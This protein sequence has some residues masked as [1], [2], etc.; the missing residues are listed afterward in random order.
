MRVR[1]LWRRA[2]EERASP[3]EIGWAIALGVFCGCSPAIGLRPL[4]ALALATPLKLNRLFAFLGS[5]LV[6][7]WL[8]IPW[9]LMLEIQVAHWLRTREL[10]PLTTRDVV[11]AGRA[12]IVDWLLGSVVVGVAAAALLGLCAYALTRWRASRR[13]KRATALEG[14]TAA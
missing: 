13:A 11:H 3:K 10:L 14:A 4:L 12:L 8:L 9:V 2:R 5:H 1:D 6:S 7:N